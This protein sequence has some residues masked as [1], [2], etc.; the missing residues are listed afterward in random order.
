MSKAQV[1]H[2]LGPPEAMV[3]Q[4][5]PVRDPAPGEVRVRH[6]A[7][8]V[9]YA[10]TY[11]RAGVSHPWVVPPCPVVIGFGPSGM[12]AALVLAQMGLKP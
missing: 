1:I 5:W 3:W 8:G 12:F 11:H 7:I 9:N 2:K 4:D 6:T 10:D